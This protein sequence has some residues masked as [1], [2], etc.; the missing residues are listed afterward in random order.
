VK[1]LGYCVLGECFPSGWIGRELRA[2]FLD[3]GLI[4]V[5]THPKTLV[6]NDLEGADR[7]FSLFARG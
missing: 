7:V 4:D 1:C 3:V 6:C 5:E 2:L